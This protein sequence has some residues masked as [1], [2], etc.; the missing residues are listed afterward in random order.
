MFI[1]LCL[2]V[3]AFGWNFADVRRGR[4]GG[5][6]RKCVSPRPVMEWILIGSYWVSTHHV[7]A[8]TW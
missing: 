1:F 5:G 6:L 3:E 7:V 8:L 4:N 2:P